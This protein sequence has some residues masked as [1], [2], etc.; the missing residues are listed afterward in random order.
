MAIRIFI[1]AL[2][3][4]AS[5][6]WQ[7]ATAQATIAVRHDYEPAIIEEQARY[8]TDI[9][10]LDSNVHI[11]ISFQHDLPEGVAGYTRYHDARKF[12]GGHQLHITINRKAGRSHQLKTLAHEIV[13]ARQFVEGKLVQC[14]H[15]HFSWSEDICFDISHIA[16][17]DR[18]W[19]KEAE[20][21]GAQLHEMYRQQSVTL[22]DY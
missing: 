20:E 9:F 4:M 12:G 17:H 2:S 6:I 16:Y 8:Y 10:G 15:R 19:E 22:T 11:L 3:L 1:S 18:P 7:T 21:V 13:H 5:L 14:D